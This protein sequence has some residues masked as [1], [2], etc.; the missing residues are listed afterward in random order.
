MLRLLLGIAALLLAFGPTSSSADTSAAPPAVWEADRFNLLPRAFQKDPRLDVMI[1][2]EYTQAGRKLPPPSP[3]RPQYFVQLKGA[4]TEVGDVIAG[5]RKPPDDYLATILRESLAQA[6]YLPADRGHPPA[7][8]LFYRWGSF[9]KLSPIDDPTGA[10]GPEPD[11]PLQS[12]NLVERAALVGGTKFAVEM[13]HAMQSGTLNFLESSSPRTAFLVQLARGNLYFLMASAY[14]YPAAA[15]GKRVLLW[16]TKVSTDSNGVAMDES[17]PQLVAS[18][19]PYF[20]HETGG[21]VRLNRPVVKEGKVLFGVPVVKEY[22]PP[23]APPPPGQ[24]APA[25]GPSA[26]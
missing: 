24:A 6:G 17:I 8:A 16:S 12:L 25:G 3:G 5:E 4:Y 23:D 10:N 7:I 1:V 20:G 2:T 18:A 13:A 11:D 19:G 22:L 9:N 26:R 15:Q 14:D 21:P